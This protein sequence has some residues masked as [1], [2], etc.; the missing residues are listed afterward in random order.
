MI[1]HLEADGKLWVT[2]EVPDE[3]IRLPDDIVVDDPNFEDVVVAV[4]PWKPVGKIKRW[5]VSFIPML[6][7]KHNVEFRGKITLSTMF[8]RCVSEVPEK[9][10]A[11]DVANTL[12]KLMGEDNSTEKMLEYLFSLDN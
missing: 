5:R 4:F 6:A 8:T 3:D 11:I 10:D 9:D 12:I 1:S 7:G 2:D